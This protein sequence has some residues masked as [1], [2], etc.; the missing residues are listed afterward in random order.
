MRNGGSRA[1]A[2]IFATSRHLPDVHNSRALSLQAPR[3]P[4]R[5]GNRAFESL[6]RSPIDPDIFAAFIS[7]EG[8]IFQ[9]GEENERD[10]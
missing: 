2:A 7:L 5:D 4:P 8:L 10:R 1:K 9:V 6:P 3:L